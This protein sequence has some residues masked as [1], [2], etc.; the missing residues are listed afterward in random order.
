MQVQCSKFY[1]LAD[2]KGERV[3]KNLEPTP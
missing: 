2:I 1:D 3:S